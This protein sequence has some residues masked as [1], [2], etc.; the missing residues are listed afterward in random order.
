MSDP[1][2]SRADVRNIAVAVISATIV[3]V[4][5]VA[6]A[7][8]V[9]VEVLKDRVAKVTQEVAEHERRLAKIEESLTEVVVRQKAIDRNTRIGANAAKDNGEKIETLSRD[10][11]RLIGY[12]D[13]K[14]A[15]K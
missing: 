15:R 12:I 1:N 11:N 3:S 2:P 8:E 4:G 6:I 5:S 14:E 10:L 13:R 7:H 9:S